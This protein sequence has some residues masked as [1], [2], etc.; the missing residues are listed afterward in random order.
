MTNYKV[1]LLGLI[2]ASAAPTT[3]ATYGNN[4]LFQDW[5]RDKEG[6]FKHGEYLT[7]FRIGGQQDVDIDVQ[8][9]TT[10]SHCGARILDSSIVTP[11]DASLGSP[12]EACPG[13]GPGVGAAGA[14]DGSAP[15]CLDPKGKPVERLLIDQVDG[16]CG[17]DP[18]PADGGVITFTFPEPHNVQDIG[19]LNA[20]ACIIMS[21]H[22]HM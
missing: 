9:S 10:T 2:A 7:N 18:A 12:N 16:D 3:V 14:P 21:C 20:G 5:V 1:A 19:I 11:A 6:R 13:G 15:N 17:A 8:V 22:R 4:C